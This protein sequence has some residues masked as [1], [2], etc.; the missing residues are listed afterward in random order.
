MSTE[1]R[2]PPAP[3]SRGHDRELWVGLLVVAGVAATLFTLFTL[4]DAALFRG[5][6]IVVTRVKEAGGIRKGDPVQ[7]RGVNIGRVLRFRMVPEGVA[8]E[9]E[10]EGEYRPPADS[11]VELKSASLL[12]GMVAD[13]IP[14]TS[15]RLLRGGDAL[16]GAT[17]AGVFDKVDD[18]T[19]QGRNALDRVQ[20]L[21]NEQTVENVQTSSGELKKLLAELNRV[22]AEQR[23]E[24]AE[25]TRSLNRSAAGI[26]KATAGPELETTVKRLEALSGRLDEV[27]GT[28][29]RS[30]RSAEAVLARIESGEGALGR[31]TRDDTLYVNANEA[32]VNLNKA[33][34][35]FARLAEDVRRQPKRYVKLSLF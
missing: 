20:A 34:T 21:L 18:L 14:G 23:K 25:L 15:T 10:I 8:V 17:G 2:L 5:R 4:T 29:D 22:T 35:E 7:M 28:L 30:S 11:R 31:L 19:A 12:G 13:V 3:P 33:A 27:V 26:E 6:Y 1:N 9:L 24:V 16:P 32:M